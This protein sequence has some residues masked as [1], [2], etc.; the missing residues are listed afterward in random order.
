MLAPALQRVN[1]DTVR[2]VGIQHYHVLR[3]YKGC[4]SKMAALVGSDEATEIDLCEE[5]IVSSDTR[6]WYRHFNGARESQRVVVG[7]S[8]VG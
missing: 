3:T 1:Q 5:R 6:D 2:V 4:L 7:C 8:G